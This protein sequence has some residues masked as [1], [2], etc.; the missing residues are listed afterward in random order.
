MIPKD[1]NLKLY[2]VRHGESEANLEKLLVTG[3]SHCSPLTEKGRRQAVKLGRVLK[4][5]DIVF[6]QVY[7]S[8]SKRALQTAEL[9]THE[10]DFAKNAIR[11][12]DR[13]V[14]Y[15]LGA[16]AGSVRSEIY[17]PEVTNAMNVLGPYFTPPEGESLVMVQRRV[18]PWL[19]DE[20]I[21]KQDNMGKI[22]NIGVFTHAMTIRVL[23]QYILGFNDRLINKVR[24]DNAG[25]SIVRFTENGW[26]L[27]GVNL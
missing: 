6:D 23:L 19:L 11:Q 10:L 27:D 9:A 1:T 22:L 16:W 5:K 14:E 2:I 18:L 4:R 13:L 8:S 24:I 20:I 15:S 25:L 26:F 3:R 21:Y 12:D 7:C 17:T